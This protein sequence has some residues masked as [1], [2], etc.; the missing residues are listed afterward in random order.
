V[1]PANRSNEELMRECAERIG[2]LAH[3][4]SESMAR[5]TEQFSIAMSDFA[6]AMEG[7]NRMVNELMTRPTNPTVGHIWFDYTNAR[8]N[9]WDGQRWRVLRMRGV[10]MQT[11]DDPCPELGCTLTMEECAEQSNRRAWHLLWDHLNERQKYTLWWKG[12]FITRDANGVVCI[13]TA[14]GTFGI[15]LLDHTWK[16]TQKKL[17]AILNMAP[18]VFMGDL[19]LAQKLW[20]ETKPALFR[21]IANVHPDGRPVMDIHGDVT[22]VVEIRRVLPKPPRP[23]LEPGCPEAI[24]LHRLHRDGLQTYLD[25]PLAERE[26]DYWEKQLKPKPETTSKFA[27]LTMF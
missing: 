2:V 1:V 10:A 25:L 14:T 11:L 16:H 6:R 17:C 15:S 21:A 8:W 3:Q 23:A 20:L 9:Q 26:W 19:L 5:V 13:I 22:E 4:F 27:S 18:Y 12:G 24:Y 7:P